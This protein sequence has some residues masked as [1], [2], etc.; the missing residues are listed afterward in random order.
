MDEFWEMR[1]SLLVLVFHIQP[2]RST[3]RSTVTPRL[4]RAFVLIYS[5]IT[6]LME[7]SG[8]YRVDLHIVAECFLC[9]LLY[10]ALALVVILHH[11]FMAT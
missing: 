8:V 10:I 3:R 7:S 6:G 9:V 2:C 1:V 4:M 11:T 5:L